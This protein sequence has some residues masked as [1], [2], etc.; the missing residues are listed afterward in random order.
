[1]VGENE[2][3]RADRPGGF[4][5]KKSFGYAFTSRSALGVPMR[6]WSRLIPA[7]RHTQKHVGGRSLSWQGPT[8][9]MPVP[10]VSSALCGCCVLCGRTHREK[11]RSIKQNELL[12]KQKQDSGSQIGVS[13]PD[14]RHYWSSTTKLPD[15]GAGGG[16]SAASLAK[17][18]F[19]RSLSAGFREGA[20]ASSRS[21]SSLASPSLRDRLLR[22]CRSSAPSSPPPSFS[23]SFSPD[24]LGRFF[25]SSSPGAT[26]GEGEWW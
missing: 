1:M 3:K 26:A 24:F 21:L 2:L 12:T 4:F 18:S 15:E 17:D 7:A 5:R 8:S 25:L 20:S 11:A 13:P 6:T 23:R 22:A 9:T 10:G 16:D 19:D 14:S